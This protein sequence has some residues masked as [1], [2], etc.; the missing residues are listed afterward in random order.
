MFSNIRRAALA[1][2]GACLAL[3]LFA[4][5]HDYKAGGI[6]IDHPWASPSP[7]G[8]AMASGYLT[9]ANTGSAPDRLLGATT[10]QA[11]SLEPHSM[12]MSGHVMQMRPISGGLAI[13]PGQTLAIQPGGGV[14]LMFV[15]PKHPFRV[16]DHI[17]ATLRFEHAGEVKVVFYVQ[18]APPAGHEH[19]GGRR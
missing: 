19:M 14:H 15:H 6:R 17:P 5:A 10:S 3:P 7:N 4:L 13:A 9:I 2:A 11:A 12:T 1:A 8:A 18:D 16:G